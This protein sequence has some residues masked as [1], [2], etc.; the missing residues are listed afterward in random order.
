M[1]AAGPCTLYCQKV[2]GY[3]SLNF[4]LIGAHH[5]LRIFPFPVSQKLCPAPPGKAPLGLFLPGG[6]VHEDLAHLFSA[7]AFFDLVVLQCSCAYRFMTFASLWLTA[8]RALNPSLCHLGFFWCT[9]NTLF[10]TTTCKLGFCGKA[11]T[12]LK[13]RTCVF[14][15]L[16]VSH[17]T[18]QTVLWAACTFSHRSHPLLLPEPLSFPE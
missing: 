3:C 10:C 14:M 6:S 9:L 8:Y 11:R 17:T 18:F 2:V 16:K 13:L 15:H 12:S 7:E 4:Y 1:A 5:Y